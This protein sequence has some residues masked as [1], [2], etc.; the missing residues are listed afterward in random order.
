MGIQALKTKYDIKHIVQLRDDC[1]CIGSPY[2]GDIIKVSFEGKIIKPYKKDGWSVNFE[3]HR[4][5]EEMS[6]DEKSG[7]LK[8]IIDSKDV[9]EINLPVFYSENGRVYKT[10]CQEYGYPNTTNEGLLMYENTFFKTKSEARKFCLKET[11][12]G[13]KYAAKRNVEVFNEC[14]RLTGRALKYIFRELRFWI[15]ARLINF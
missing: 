2:I 4:Y 12:Y 6:V 3:L 5:Q 8:R 7:E 11:N 10:F 1:I 15:L 13:V 14:R 9:F